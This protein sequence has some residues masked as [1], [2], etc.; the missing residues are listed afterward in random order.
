MKNTD[1]TPKSISNNFE[2][3]YNNHIKP[4]PSSANLLDCMDDHV[5]DI[6]Q[7]PIYIV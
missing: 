6:K 1:L 3:L 4:I 7:L 2:Y 5:I